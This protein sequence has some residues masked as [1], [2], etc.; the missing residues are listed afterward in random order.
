MKRMLAAGAVMK[1]GEGMAGTILESRSSTT[2]LKPQP[3]SRYVVK[4]PSVTNCVMR[5]ALDDLSVV[6][7]TGVEATGKN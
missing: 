1:G 4:P 2:H 7:K 3:P 6:T 5:Q